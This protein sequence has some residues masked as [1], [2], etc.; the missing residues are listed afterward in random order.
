VLSTPPAFVLS[1]DQTLQQKPVRKNLKLAT[2]KLVTKKPQPTHKQA[3]QDG[4]KPTLALASQT[5]C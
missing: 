1:Q 5:P 2:K 4:K 3:S